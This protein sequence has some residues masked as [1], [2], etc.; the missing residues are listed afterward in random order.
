MAKIN[1]GIWFVRILYIS[2]EPL[3]SAPSSLRNRFRKSWK[4]LE[5][6]SQKN[7]LNSNLE[8][9]QCSISNPRDDLKD[10]LEWLTV[11]F[12][13]WRTTWSL[14]RISS[15]YFNLVLWFFSCVS[16]STFFELNINV[17]KYCQLNCSILKSKVSDES[18]LKCHFNFHFSDL[19]LFEDSHLHAH[20]TVWHKGVN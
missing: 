14:Y 13:M 12:A 10:F 17:Q 7:L 3:Q 4:I 15:S 19:T 2:R 20:F 5:S 1:L 8:I 11:Q 6:L 9:F 16:L 18:I